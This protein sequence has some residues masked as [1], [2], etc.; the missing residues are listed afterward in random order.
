MGI[1]PVHGEVSDLLDSV[2][3][4]DVIRAGTITIEPDAPLGVGDNSVGEP[5]REGSISAAR[6]W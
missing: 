6:C 2:A 1:H 4:G 5:I 3:V